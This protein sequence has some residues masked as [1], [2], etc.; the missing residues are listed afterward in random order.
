MK[1]RYAAGAASCDFLRVASLKRKQ[2]RVRESGG[3][4]DECFDILKWTWD[5]V[6]EIAPVLDAGC[7]RK[8]NE[9]TQV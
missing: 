8:A 5:F 9:E 6:R 7:R 3:Q 4:I 1:C 2:D